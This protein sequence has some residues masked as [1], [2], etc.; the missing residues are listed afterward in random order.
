MLKLS[1]LRGEILVATTLALETAFDFTV[2]ISQALINR[3]LVLKLS[4]L[5]CLLSS[6]TGNLI[7]QIQQL[8][9]FGL[10]F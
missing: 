7:F 6:Q 4:F 1:Y 9:F 2:F 3:A 5:S 10:K 8:Y